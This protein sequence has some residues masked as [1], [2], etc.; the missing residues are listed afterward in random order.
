MK[1]SEILSYFVNWG[2][3]NF[4]N[5]KNKEKKILKIFNNL[6]LE[7]YPRQ[8]DDAL[9]IINAIEEHGIFSS[10]G[11]EKVIHRLLDLWGLTDLVEVILDY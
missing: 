6:L 4:L 2:F 8:V 1:T 5:L 9:N 3:L 11:Y 7:R 10:V